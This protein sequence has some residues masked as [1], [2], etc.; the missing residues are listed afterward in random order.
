MDRL[1]FMV[2]PH[3]TTNNPD[4]W[5]L[6]AQYMSLNCSFRVGFEMSFDFADFHENL[7]K[8][9]LV[10]ANPNDTLKLVHEHG[11]KPLV[12]AEGVY[13]EVVFV[14]STA[15]A[16]P[17]LTDLN[18]VDI[19]SVNRMLPTKIG[20][21]VLHRAN[22]NPAQVVDNASWLSVVA[23]MRDHTANYAFLYKDTYTSLS[24]TNKASLQAFYTSEEQIAFHSLLLRPTHADKADECRQVLLGMTESPEGREVLDALGFTA[25]KTVTPGEF[26]QME[27]LA[28]S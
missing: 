2:C 15:V 25:W 23:A 16:T 13:D 11:Y 27:A 18:G 6:F 9:D 8:A 5:F 20:L 14:A 28:K 4:K 19:Y 3:D 7:S 22:I 17:T 21:Q 24:D 26:T 12:H 1:Q 10:Y